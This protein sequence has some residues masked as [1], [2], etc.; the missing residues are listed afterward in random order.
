[1]TLF[2][3]VFSFMAVELEAL[4]DSSKLLEISFRIKLLLQVVAPCHNQSPSPSR[5]KAPLP[6][7]RD[8]CVNLSFAAIGIN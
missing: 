2:V 5:R 8:E 7:V 3:S 1:M 4:M 6:A